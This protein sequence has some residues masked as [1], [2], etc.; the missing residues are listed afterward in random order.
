VRIALLFLVSFVF[1]LSFSLKGLKQHDGSRKRRLDKYMENTQSRTSEIV[2]NIKTV[3]AFATESA[4]L[5]RQRQRL[6]REFK[7]V[8]YRIHLG[9]IKLATGKG[10]SFSFVSLWS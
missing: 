8:D 6:E 2:T 1:I 7:V 4:E 5:N 10:L 9:Y 3:K